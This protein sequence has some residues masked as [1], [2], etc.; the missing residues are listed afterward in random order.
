M[1]PARQQWPQRK[2]WP[3]SHRDVE[4]NPRVRLE[5]ACMPPTN[6]SL[7]CRSSF[8]RFVSRESQFS[9]A[10]LATKKACAWPP[11][12]LCNYRALR[13]V[14]LRPLAFI[15]VAISIGIAGFGQSSGLE[16]HIA[17]VSVDSTQHNAFTDPALKTYP[18]PIKADVDLVLIPVTVTDPNDRLITGLESSN[19]LLYDGDTE[20]KIRYFWREDAPISLGVIFDMSASMASKIDKAREAVVQFLRTAN[21]Q[22]ECFLVAFSDR[23]VLLSDFTDSADDIQ[24]RLVGIVPDHQTALL[25]AIYLGLNEMR[26]AK[27]QK[28]ALLVISDG[29]DNHSRYTEN[30]IKSIVKE[31]DVQIYAV[32]I[33]DASPRTKEERLGPALLGE[34]TDVTGGRSF[35]IGNPGELPD[36]SAKIAIELRNQYVLAYHPTNPVHD[37]KW[38]K[39]KV[40]LVPP[41]GLP[42]LHLYA[43]KGYY[44]SSQ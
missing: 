2:V 23:P 43:K 25:D 37:G 8:P 42:S 31:A 3:E 40:K 36:V 29:G 1:K 30:E 34:I 22:D 18:R 26:H 20:E 33:F 41:K 28:K 10:V 32:G 6:V 12:S 16:V 4:I 44:G 13:L 19:F 24:N 21:R 38:H 9:A 17:P 5:E 15:L 7:R 39:V 11:S 14:K 27:Y 35:T